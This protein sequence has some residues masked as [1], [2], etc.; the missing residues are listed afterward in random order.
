MLSG[1][2]IKIRL[3]LGPTI[4]IVFIY[5]INANRPGA[6]KQN[7]EILVLYLHYKTE[8]IYHS[9]WFGKHSCLNLNPSSSH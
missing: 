8:K 3:L 6:R 7:I 1:D 4:S 5:N 2:K 9:S